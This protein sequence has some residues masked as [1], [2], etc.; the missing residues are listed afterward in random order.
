MQNQHSLTQ[1]LEIKAVASL[2]MQFSMKVLQMSS[3][4]LKN[5][6]YDSF[7][8]NP[9]LEIDEY[10]TL[11]SGEEVEN[12]GKSV[13]KDFILN[14]ATF[15]LE[16]VK[17]PLEFISKDKTFTDY[18]I[19]Q[20]GYLDLKPSMLKLCKYIVYSLDGRGY[21]KED[22][23][24]EASSNK[25]SPNL[26]YEALML[27]RNLEPLG[28]G[29]Q[30]LEESLI[31]QL[32]RKGLMTKVYKEIIDNHLE[33]VAKGNYH[34][35]S[36]EM[37][38][39]EI[40]VRQ[41]V[42]DIKELNPIPSRGFSENGSNSYIIP[43]ADI[44]KLGDHLLISMNDQMIPKIRLN[45]ELTK[46]IQNDDLELSTYL[47]EKLKHAKMMMKSL[48]MRKSTLEKVINVVVEN[49]HDYLMEKQ[50]HL[51][52]LSLKSVAQILD[53]HESTISRAVREKYISTSRGTLA[54]KNLFSTSLSAV[55][56][57]VSSDY[58]KN[59]IKKIIHEEDKRKPISD[60][61]ITEILNE[62]G[63]DIKRRTIAKYRI[64]ENI[65][66]TKIRKELE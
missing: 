34:N 35:L 48:E 6:I 15:T 43:D 38:V 22:Y 39:S 12:N 52:P 3:G 41:V 24:E 64:E 65:P 60:Q 21:Y 53:V 7:S 19:E 37:N 29:W 5:F 23:Q 33:K 1:G 40:I 9:I 30:T 46:T 10:E 56:T 63:I 66:S 61:K 31:F 13:D 57:D 11:S 54:L 45:S 16:S 62:R 32:E 2:E 42:D 44:V 14:A 18:L 25:V 47:I 8:E 20:I 50:K 49:Q 27:I 26:F 36:K 59:Q 58:I 51:E 4:E 55:G 28:I 17:S